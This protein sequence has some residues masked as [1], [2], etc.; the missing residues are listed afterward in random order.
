M[1][2]TL[3]DIGINGVKDLHFFYV[4]R[5]LRYNDRLRSQAELRRRACIKAAT[6]LDASNRTAAPS[7]PWDDPEWTE[8]SGNEASEADQSCKR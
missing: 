4:N 5:V 2:R 1:E 8:W 7:T 6:Q 3:H